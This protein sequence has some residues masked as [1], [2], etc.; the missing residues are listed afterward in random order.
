MTTF[1]TSDLHFAHSNII[2]LC[3]RPYANI[4]E[5]ED[6][7][8]TQWNS[9]VKA[10][11]IVYHLGDFSYCST[12]QS[13]TILRKLNGTKYQINGNHDKHSRHCHE[14]QSVVDYQELDVD[15]TKVVLFHYPM[16]EWNGFYRGAVHLYGH[17]HGND[18]FNGN[19]PRNCADVG[20]DS[21]DF[22]QYKL[23]NLDH[24]VS[25]FKTVS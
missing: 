22:G 19:R 7:I 6:A 4:A 20:W 21:E 23:H 24:I 2:K 14:W 17:V 10:G 5:M 11:D 18:P 16:M 12:F 3:N 15:G 8:V 25:H 9:Q 13:S 1:V